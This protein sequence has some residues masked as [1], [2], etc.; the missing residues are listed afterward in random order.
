MAKENAKKM[1]L[2]VKI[3][4]E[5]LMHEKLRDK[6]GYKFLIRKDKTPSLEN[7]DESDSEE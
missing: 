2:L 5:L 6:M 3:K 1:Q 7:S 4:Q